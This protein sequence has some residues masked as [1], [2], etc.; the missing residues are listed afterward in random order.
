[1]DA[2]LQ[3]RLLSLGLEPTR[4]PGTELAQRIASDLVKWHDLMQAA[5]IHSG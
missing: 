5:N 1:M 3:H 2:D 4:T